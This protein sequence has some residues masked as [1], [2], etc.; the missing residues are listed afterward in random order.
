MDDAF[1]IRNKIAKEQLF[2]IA[3][4]GYLISYLVFYVRYTYFSDNGFMRF[5][6]DIMSMNPPCNDLW[7][8]INASS[9]TI[10][11][12]SITGANFV[13]SP[14]FVVIYNMLSK[15][16]YLSLRWISYLSIILSYVYLTFKNPLNKY[17]SISNISLYIIITGFVSYGLRFELERGQWNLQTILLCFTA[18][19]LKDHTKTYIKIIAYLLFTVAIHLKDWPLIFIFNFINLNESFLENI[20]T[21]SIIFLLNTISLFVLGVKFLQEF[22]IKLAHVTANPEPWV[23]NISLTCFNIQLASIY[24]LNLHSL[25]ILTCI[26]VLMFFLSIF[27]AFHKKINGNN[28]LILLLCSTGAILFPSTSFDYKICIL[29][30]FLGYFFNCYELISV[31]S[32]TAICIIKKANSY[33]ISYN[34]KY[35]TELS[36]LS[37]ILLLYPPTLYSYIY[38]YSLGYIGASDSLYVI[39]ISICT[40]MLIFIQP[41]KNRI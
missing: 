21:I 3:I 1:K 17:K 13:Y 2:I 37:L 5:P 30:V 19:K 33:K 16:N 14:L 11:A 12:G 39:L 10:A 18:L 28:P 26:Y 25:N 32:S 7:A 20:K 4:L 38:K 41:N 34:L 23:A 27:I 9:K 8:S 29:T 6:L 22:I 35:I 36:L 31:N 15:I 40:M 24:N